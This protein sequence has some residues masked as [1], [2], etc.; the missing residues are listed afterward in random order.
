MSISCRFKA[1]HGQEFCVADCPAT[2]A[3]DVFHYSKIHRVRDI[4][5]A[6]P[7]IID[8]A[9]LDM[10]HGWPNL[11]HDSLVHLV[12]DATCDAV[13]AL[14][15]A[16]L[17]IRVLSFDVRVSQMLPE[18][19]GGR[20]SIYL[21]T[22]GP[23]NI[24]PSQN[25]G[26]KEGS[27]GIRENS[28]WEKRAFQLF[29]AIYADK[30]AVLLG[31]CHTFGVMCRWSGI[32]EPVLRGPEKGGK[33]TGILENILTPAAQEHPWFG[34]FAKNLPD[35]WRLRIADNRLFDLVPTAPFHNGITVIG[36]ETMGVGGPEGNAIT[37]LEWSRDSEGTMPRIFAVNHHPEI[38][39]RARQLFILERKRERGEVTR[40]WYEERLDIL[41]RNYP[42]ED[43]ENLLAL[44]SDYTIVAPLRYFLFRQIRQ[45]AESMG[46]QMEWNE[47]QVLKSHANGHKILK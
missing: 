43:S 38:M 14:Q 10:N 40:T 41:T 21:G 45:R 3:G 42:G 26:V 12:Q 16:G 30:S 31:V 46:I 9:A 2:A 5:P 8:V 19:P 25:D 34:H 11:G 17:Q 39:N 23:G 28:E 20:Y 36:R 4:P 37:M 6:D 13:P 24:D 22:G 7:T 33:S 29:D 32:A 44:T 35:H 47:D 27:Q 15:A 18:P 1:A